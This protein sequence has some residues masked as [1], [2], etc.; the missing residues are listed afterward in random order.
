[1]QELVSLGGGGGMAVK[2]QGN[3][4]DWERDLT[5]QQKLIFAF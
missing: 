2:I 1:M 4:A 3:T 5:T